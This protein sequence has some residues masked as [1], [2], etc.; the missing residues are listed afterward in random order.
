MKKQQKKSMA[1]KLVAICGGAVL[2]LS[3]GYSIVYGADGFTLVDIFRGL[4]LLVF[5]LYMEAR[6]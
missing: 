5:G 3:L 4:A 6:E 1:G 2:A